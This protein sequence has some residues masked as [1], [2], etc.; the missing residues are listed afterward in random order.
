MP[1]RAQRLILKFGSGILTNP[2]G[3]GL[4]RRQFARLSTEVA[5]LAG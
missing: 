3:N 4:D 5:A 2:R 1:A